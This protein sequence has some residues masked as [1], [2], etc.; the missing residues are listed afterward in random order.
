MPLTPAWTKLRHHPQQ[1]KLW[2]TRARFI[3][4]AC[5]RG[6]GKTE[7]ARRRVVRLLPVRK[8]W[9][10]PMY[11][12][13]LPTY[14][15]AKRVAWQEILDLI[16]PDW[17][18]K[19]NLSEMCVETRFG[20][21]LWI[22]GMDKPERIEGSQWDGGVID[23]SCDQKPG[24]FA[25][26]VLPALSHRD[27]WCWRIGVPKRSGPGAAEFKQWC[28]GIDSTNGPV[29]EESY[30][31]PSSDIL[32]EEKLRWARENLDPKD[33]NEQY[34]ANWE[35]VGG[36]VFYGY[37][38]ELDVDDSIGPDP[39]RPLIIGS[40][41]N[42]D[43]MSW[44][45]GQ[46]HGGPERSKQQLHIFDE[47]FIRNTNTRA[48]LDEL[49][50]RWGSHKAGFHFFG[51]ATAQSRNTRASESDYIQIRNDKRFEGARVFYPKKNPRRANRFASC[52]ALFCN[53]TG[54]RRFKVRSN[55][56]NLRRD[57]TTRAYAEGTSEP[58]DYGDV[59]HITDALGYIIHRIFPI[60]YAHD[61]IQ[62][63]YASEF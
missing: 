26:S 42:V 5:G 44:V 36:L 33:Y 48:T 30:T 3:G 11:F 6:S 1:S 31:W 38:D 60:K 29:A 17:I 32:S 16:P 46:L 18:S 52:N 28:V 25:R 7:L 39:T 57:L 55:C 37:V 51:D 2:R 50:K 8:P 58:D 9:P 62:G 27:G 61:G 45:I 34:G 23:E 14:K 4:A 10:R 35:T 22:T 24:S 59:G 63:V 41:F 12:Y 40:D 56:R 54:A 20:S 15:Q 53:A 43:P 21:Q 49:Y 47:L 19:A 13:A